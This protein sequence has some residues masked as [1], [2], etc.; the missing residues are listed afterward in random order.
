MNAELVNKLRLSLDMRAAV[1]E[2]PEP[3][4]LEELGVEDQPPFDEMDAGTYDF[5]MLF[6]KDIASLNE[7][8]PKALKAVK[9]DGLL[10]ICYPKGT[11]KIR[12]DINRDRGWKA[13]KDEGWEGV[14]LVS[15]DETWSA[16]RF[17]PVGMAQRSARAS[18][19]ADIGRP[20]ATVAKELVIP[21]DVTAALDA[22]PEAAAF[23]AELAPSHRKEYIRWINEAK[24]E[25]T[26]AKRIHE[27][28]DKLLLKLKRPS[29]KPNA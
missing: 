28:T 9:R 23:F 17:R 3:S 29:E 25:V 4:Y 26:R 13:V 8:A 19:A 22:K 1:L 12:T 18:R 20:T 21:D 10:W 5:V 7:H 6:A 2:T 16:M 24:Q 14:S 27:M 11:A 15:V